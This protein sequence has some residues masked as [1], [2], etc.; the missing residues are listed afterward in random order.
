MG[1]DA[2]EPQVL[3]LRFAPLRMTAFVVRIRAPKTWRTL[4]C[5]DV[6]EKQILRCA[7][8]DKFGSASGSGIHPFGNLR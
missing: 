7:Q 3:R 2:G 6:D 8:D 5:G 1:G 4:I